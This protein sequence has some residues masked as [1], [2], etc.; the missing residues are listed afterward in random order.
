MIG[1]A[2]GEPDPDRAGPSRT[3]FLDAATGIFVLLALGLAL[4][5]IIA[6]LIPGSGFA[7]DL[8]SFKFWAT[9]LA[10]EGLVRASTTGRS[11]TTTRP[12]TCTC[13]GSSAASANLFGGGVGDLIKLPPMVADLALG[14]LVWSMVK[15]LGGSERSARIGAA[16]VLFNPVTWF[17]SVVWGQ[18]DSFGVVFLL[19]ALREL[20]RDRPERAA[21]LATVAALIKPQLG[22]LIPIVAIVVIRRAFWPAGGFGAEDGAGAGRHDHVAGS[23]AS[24]GRS[25]SSP[26]ASAALL[27]AL[28]GLPA[29][30][31][32]LPVRAHRPDLQ[33][34]GRL[35]VP[36]GQ[37]VQPVGP[38]H[39]HDGRRLRA[40]HR[41]EPELGLRLDDRRV[42]TLASSASDRS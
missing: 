17:D 30:R 6:Y 35:P 38:V 7:V 8:S 32:E 39:P 18:V 2:L 1:P 22:I 40:E 16:L 31:A 25:G 41:A 37:R 34:R 42:A 24:E 26:R 20:W 33:D 10:D 21:I 13:C 27:T 9:N 11:S 36:V 29:L 5:L 14:Y 3:G 28:A 19:L 15:E 4:R 12:A 23:G